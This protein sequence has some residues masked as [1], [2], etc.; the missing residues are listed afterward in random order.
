MYIT[1]ILSVYIIYVK[2]SC[3]PVITERIECATWNLH[4]DAHWMQDHQ[5]TEETP[6]LNRTRL[7]TDANIE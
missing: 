5:S 4:L 2:S 3:T 1:Y 6:C 7:T